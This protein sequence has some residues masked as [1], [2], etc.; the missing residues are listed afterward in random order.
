MQ[1]SVNFVY[2]TTWT[3]MLMCLHYSK[4]T[5][6]Y[7]PRGEDRL[8]RMTV[9]QEKDRRRL[10]LQASTVFKM[11]LRHSLLEAPMQD[12]SFYLRNRASGP[13]FAQGKW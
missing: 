9:A 8:F 13:L 1:F 2:V 11:H 7:I 5:S 3:V 4:V 12:F 6:C 10:V